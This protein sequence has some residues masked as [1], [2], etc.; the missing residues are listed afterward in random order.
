MGQSRTGLAAV[1]LEQA[2]H[3][4]FALSIVQLI[5][6]KTCVRTAG[7]SF[8]EV[9]LKPGLRRSDEVT[10]ARRARRLEPARAEFPRG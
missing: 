8:F 9:R 1:T 2:G 10:D 4:T 5:C 7:A 6:P 3:I